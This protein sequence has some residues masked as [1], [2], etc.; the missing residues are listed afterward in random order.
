[1]RSLPKPAAK[2]R[3]VMLACSG[4][5][6]DQDLRQRLTLILDVLEAAEVHYEQRGDAAELYQ[7]EG[8][9]GVG[10]N[11]TKAEMTSVYSDKLSKDGQP[12]RP[13]YDV[14]RASSPHGICPLCAQRPVS[15]LD[16]YLAKS[17]HPTFAVTPLN[18]V[19]A[20]FDC[21]KAKL[22]TG[23]VNAGDQ[24]LHPYFD[25]VEDA[26][27]LTA[28]LVENTP[29]AVLFAAQPPDAWP[30]TKQDRV[31]TH[32]NSLGLAALYGANAAQELA[33]MTHYLSRI[34][35]AGGPEGVQLH[36]QELATSKQAPAR[37]SWQAAL[38]VALADSQWFWSGGH[39]N[40]VL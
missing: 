19:P 17:T 10:A 25:Y 20:C 30:Q 24:T 40:I 1:M 22:A 38:Y 26:T 12:G 36:L 3:D 18:L 2:V 13:Y 11:V 7:I 16:H 39:R 23:A 8:T 15:T 31:R 14:L 27:W 21:N 28:A 35:D 4:N 5:I 37:N 33:Q 32:F 9:N 29:P 6:Q 34:A